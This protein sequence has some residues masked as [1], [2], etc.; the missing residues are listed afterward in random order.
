M[1]SGIILNNDLCCQHHPSQEIY[2]KVLDL[3]WHIAEIL[4]SYASDAL[5]IHPEV[6]M[7]EYMRPES[8]Q[9]KN[10]KYCKF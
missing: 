6:Q 2:Y 3:L 5:E 10:N 7:N 8:P 4:R 1:P 9:K